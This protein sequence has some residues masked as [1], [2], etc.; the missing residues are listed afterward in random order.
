[1]VSLYGGKIYRY[2]NRLYHIVDRKEEEGTV[3]IS[4]I[5]NPKTSFWVEESE[6]EFVSDMFDVQGDSELETCYVALGVYGR[7]TQELDFI[8]TCG[9]LLEDYANMKRFDVGDSRKEFIEHLAEMD[10]LI[11]Q[12]KILFSYEEEW[13]HIRSHKLS[14]I[15]F[16]I[17]DMLR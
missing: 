17:E 1:M 15:R 14:N 10:I 6:V 8:R 3:K 7:Y 4:K 12:M 11:E 9:R 13:E 16:N 2:H 5:T